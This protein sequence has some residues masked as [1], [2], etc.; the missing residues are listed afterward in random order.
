MAVDPSGRFAYVTSNGPIANGYVSTA[1]AKP[2]STVEL[3]SSETY[4]IAGYAIDRATGVLTALTGS[5]FTYSALEASISI[6]KMDPIGRYLYVANSLENYVWAY[7]VDSTSGA[8]TMVSG[9]PFDMGAGTTGL[10]IDPT[11]QYLYVASVDKITA[12]K[13]DPEFGLIPGASYASTN[14]LALAIDGSG[15][16]LY[17]VNHYADTNNLSAYSIDP[18]TGVLT[19]VPGSPFT[20][21]VGPNDIEVD[22][23]GKFVYV[24]NA[25]SGLLGDVSVFSIDATNGSLTQVSGSPF[26]A[27]YVP[28]SLV[29]TGQIQ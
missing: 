28:G 17:A 18:F 20:A 29:T 4:L 3:L 16:Y 13:I 10:V 19:P 21:G 1:M 25:E 27:G 23:S 8:L 12:F 24:A 11:G 6:A 2:S 9:S 22:F 15:H 26:A 5:P 14:P 7:V